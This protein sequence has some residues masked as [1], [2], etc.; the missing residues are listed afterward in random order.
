MAGP[1]R[2]SA[3]SRPRSRS[4]RGTAAVR[5]LRHPG[6]L[7]RPIAAPS[8]TATASFGDQGNAV[9]L[10]ARGTTGTWS[11]LARSPPTLLGE[12][13]EWS[14]VRVARVTRRDVAYL[15][16]VTHARR[17][18]LVGRRRYDWSGGR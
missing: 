13:R 15:G 2:P 17:L 5:R 18:W 7:T 9:L 14:V 16:F 8:F 6:R 3:G 1:A 4:P 12:N 11:V 10:T